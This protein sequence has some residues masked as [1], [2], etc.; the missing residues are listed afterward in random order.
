[1]VLINH[2]LSDDGFGF[3]EPSSGFDVRCEKNN[4]S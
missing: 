4:F 3:C 1:M 2:H